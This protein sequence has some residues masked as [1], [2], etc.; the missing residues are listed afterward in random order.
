MFSREYLIN[1]LYSPEPSRIVQQM[2]TLIQKAF[3]KT[4]SYCF[5]YFL[6]PENKRH[7]LKPLPQMLAQCDFYYRNNLKYL[8]SAKKSGSYAH[9]LPEFF[10]H[11]S[12]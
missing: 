11:F 7:P 2:N 10:R 9:R 3:F 4:N 8:L 12:Q 1:A 5:L 6:R